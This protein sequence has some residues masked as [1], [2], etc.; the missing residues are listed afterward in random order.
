[1]IKVLSLKK[2]NLRPRQNDLTNDTVETV[3]LHYL[4]KLDE[5]SH[6]QIC[7]ICLEKDTMPV[8]Q[9]GSRGI[10]VEELQRKAKRSTA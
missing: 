9:V 8:L 3:F 4:E 7:G 5:V 2:W 1:M 6:L 10:E